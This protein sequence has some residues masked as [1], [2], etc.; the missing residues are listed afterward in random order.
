MSPLMA[1]SGT[2]RDGCVWE[3]AVQTGWQSCEV[4]KD[5]PFDGIVQHLHFGS[6]IMSM[7]LCGTC[8]SYLTAT[9]HTMR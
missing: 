3:V 7:A 5:I 1:L 6:H 2:C 4:G 9:I 8:S